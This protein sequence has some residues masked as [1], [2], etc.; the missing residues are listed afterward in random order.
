[1]IIDPYYDNGT[2]GT[3]VNDGETTT[4]YT[5]VGNVTIHHI[6]GTYTDAFY[7]YDDDYDI[8][9]FP[10]KESD[11]VDEFYHPSYFWID[12]PNKIALPDSPVIDYTWLF[13]K[14]KIRAPPNAFH[15]IE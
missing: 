2:S 5:P 7:E 3:I 10:K 15:I 14:I 11:K 4:Y 6:D 1:M 13:T 8:T 12:A 9:V